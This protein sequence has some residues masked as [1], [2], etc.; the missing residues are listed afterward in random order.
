MRLHLSVLCI[1]LVGC[2]TVTNEVAN[3]KNISTP[4]SKVCIKQM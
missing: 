1:A 4:H 3:Q 2:N